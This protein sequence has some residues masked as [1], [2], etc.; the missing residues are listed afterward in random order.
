MNIKHLRKATLYLIK[1][2]KSRKFIIVDFDDDDNRFFIDE[3]FFI[4]RQ[5]IFFSNFF[6]EY[7]DMRTIDLKREKNRKSNSKSLNA[8]EIKLKKF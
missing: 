5:N 7:I 2:R 6:I 3:D 8:Q 4:R 1:S